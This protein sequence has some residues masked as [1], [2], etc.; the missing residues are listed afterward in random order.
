MTWADLGL[1]Y[2]VEPF[3]KES[4]QR[5]VTLSGLAG[6]QYIRK[7]KLGFDTLLDALDVWKAVSP[8]PFPS[9]YHNRNFKGADAL[10]ISH[11][12]MQRMGQKAGLD[13]V[14]WLKQAKPTAV[15]FMADER[16]APTKDEGERPPEMKPIRS[17]SEEET[18]EE[19]EGEPLLTKRKRKRNEQGG[20]QEPF[21]LAIGG[22]A[23]PDGD[24]GGT[25][26]L[27]LPNY[28]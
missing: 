28:F 27:E 16:E 26:W 6:D 12:D 3:Q 9:F 7:T 15:T 24:E 17:L 1:R 13:G 4:V 22:Q 18:E 25:G 5:Y 21:L 14:V 20:Q 19:S 2:N 23:R 11:G 10:R 8:T